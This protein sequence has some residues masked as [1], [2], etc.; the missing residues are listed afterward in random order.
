MNT[1]LLKKLLEQFL[2]EDIHHIDVTTNSIFPSD[3]YSKA[4]FSAKEPGVLSGSEIIQTTYSLLDPEVIVFLHKNDSEPLNAFDKIATVEGPVRSILSGERVILNLLQRMSGIATMTAIAVE[5]LDSPVT[6]IIDTRKTAPGLRM[7]DKYAI[8][9]GGGYNHRF[10]LFDGVMIKDNH[11]AFAGSIS[12]AVERVRN[13]LG[14]MVK[15]EVETETEEQVLEAVENNVDII[16]FD[17][18]KP[19]EIIQFMQLIPEG[20]LTEAS[21]GITFDNLHL[22]RDTNVHFISLG[23]LTHSVKALDISLSI[24]ENE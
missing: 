3:Y 14:P 20:I 8:T 2:L 6:K 11:I 16:M 1:V 21:G 22:Y 17:N 4:T 10:G 13:T 23:F 19:E 9:C 15:I 7:F 18:R 12:K 5:I 24:K